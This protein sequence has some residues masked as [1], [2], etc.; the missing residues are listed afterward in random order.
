MEF[1]KEGKVLGLTANTRLNLGAA[2]YNHKAAF[3]LCDVACKLE[4]YT[5]G[6]VSSGITLNSIS[7]TPDTFNFSTGLIPARLAAITPTTGAAADSKI[8]LFN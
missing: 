7:T 4:F 2:E 1:Y 6:A 8:I 3:V 5:K